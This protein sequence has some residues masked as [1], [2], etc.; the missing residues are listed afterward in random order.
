MRISVK[1][2]GCQLEAAREANGKEL[3]TRTIRETERLDDRKESR[4]REEGSA[5]FHF[6]RDD[7]TLSLRDDAVHLAENLTCGARKKI[8]TDA[9][10]NG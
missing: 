2:G 3:V 9:A 10:K 1:D 4:D 7:A 8:S 6:F 5:L